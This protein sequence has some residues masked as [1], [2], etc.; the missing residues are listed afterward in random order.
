MANQAL[1]QFPVN[2]NSMLTHSVMRIMNGDKEEE[3]AKGCSPQRNGMMVSAYL[4]SRR[5]V[6][7]QEDGTKGALS[8]LR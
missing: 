5:S 1:S 7:S 3:N 8:Q 6:G 2:F 4:F